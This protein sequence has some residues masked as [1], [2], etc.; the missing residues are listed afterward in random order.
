MS[1]T[2]ILPLSN[3]NGAGSSSRSSI[4]GDRS[5]IRDS[6]RLGLGGGSSRNGNG[7]GADAYSLPRSERGVPLV[8]RRLLK[9]RSMVSCFLRRLPSCAW[10]C[11]HSARGGMGVALANGQDFEMA[12]WQLTWLVMSPRRVYKQT[13][14]QWVTQAPPSLLL[15][16]KGCRSRI[17]GPVSR[18]RTYGHETSEPTQMHLRKSIRQLM[19]IAQ[20]C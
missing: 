4:Y 16:V 2:P 3:G 15:L 1:S 7:Y 8:L 6:L 12:F 5:S 19:D 13:Y 10:H 9:F 11:L 17:D 14:H 20:R 18:Q